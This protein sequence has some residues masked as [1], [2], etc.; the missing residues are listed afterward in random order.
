MKKLL[1]TLLLLTLPSIASAVEPSGAPIRVPDAESDGVAGPTPKSWLFTDI[2]YV[3]AHICR[4][5]TSACGPDPL[6]SSGASFNAIVRLA[7]PFGETA[8]LYLV[9][10]DTENAVVALVPGTQ[11]IPAG[12]SDWFASFVLPD[13][14]Y[15]FISI[16]QGLSTGKIG[17]SEYYRF[18]VG[19]PPSTFCCP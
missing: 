16:T 8:N 19:G 1:A 15:K 7:M 4:S 10:T 11:F 17:L 14:V 3:R 6:V 9:I 2:F 13:G 12:F 18:R 5:G